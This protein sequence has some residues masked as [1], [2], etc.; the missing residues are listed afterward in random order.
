MLFFFT[1][2]SLDKGL[3]YCICFLSRWPSKST[4]G[5]EDLNEV[6]QIL[7]LVFERRCQR[8]FDEANLLEG[9]LNKLLAN[10]GTCNV[11]LN[12]NVRSI[13]MKVKN[14]SCLQIFINFRVFFITNFN[15]KRFI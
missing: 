4:K 9:L 5:K 12:E 8:K 7:S 6:E 2:Y 10:E 15:C 11:K 13:S 14:Q 1:F 3:F